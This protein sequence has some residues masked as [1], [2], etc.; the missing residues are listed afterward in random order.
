MKKLYGVGI[1]D[2]TEVT[3][4]FETL[5][6]KPCGRIIQRRVFVCPFYICWHA[7]M[8]RA[9]SQEWHNRQP[10]YKD[11]TVCEE[12]KYFT[13][14]K[15]WM[16]TQDWE[17]KQLDKDLLFPGNKVYSPDTC[18]FVDQRV[19]NFVTDCGRA[20]GLLPIGVTMDKRTG[21]YSSRINIVGEGRVSL[22]YFSTPEEAHQAWLKAKLELARSLAAEQDNP[23]VAK[24]L[25][26]RYENY[27]ED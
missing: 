13:K 6:F 16:E 18:V 23:R 14:F 19:N 20:R 8:R 2:S 11:C 24:A 9:Y 4:R 3:Q 21:R 12:W 10:T 25:I 22:G 27:T 26:D 1:N 5:G 7:I 15:A 17:G